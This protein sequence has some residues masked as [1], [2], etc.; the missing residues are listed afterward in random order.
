MNS[1]ASK[2]L[3]LPFAILLLACNDDGKGTS[4]QG[5]S[6]GDADG[7]PT[8]TGDGD[9]TGNE[10][11]TGDG[12][13]TGDGDGDPG[14]TPGE[15]NCS[16][17]NGLCLGD[18]E[19]VNGTCANACIPGELGCECNN[20]QCLGDLE[21]SGDICIDPSC[22]PGELFCECNNGLCL[23][24]YVCTGNVCMEASGD[25]DGD[26]DGDPTGDGDGEPNPC[27][28]PNQL[29]CNGDCIDVMDDDNNCGACGK[30]CP[31]NA[32]E[33]GCSEGACLP[34]WS[35]CFVPLVD[36]DNCNDVCAAE[37]K[38]CVYLGCGSTTYKVYNGALECSMNGTNDDFK[39]PNTCEDATGTN[40]NVEAAQCCCS[41]D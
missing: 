20:G 13:A 15:L 28:L 18:L 12:D 27:P 16:C 39:L 3:V 23:G 24:D 35:E 21:C 8:T 26:G 32:E 9:P 34:F 7:D 37:G 10:D 30:V 33:G 25:G 40:P 41:V 29:P 22:T 36:F 4:E 38:T 14:C 5:G 1:V 2:L 31:K 11:P 6:T 17:N 19:C